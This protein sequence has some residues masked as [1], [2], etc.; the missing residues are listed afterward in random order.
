MKARRWDFARREY[1]EVE[2]ADTCSTY[3]DDF[4]S[5]VTC[6]GCGR[7]LP[8]GHTFTSFMYHD[9]VGFGYGVCEACHDREFLDRLCASRESGVGDE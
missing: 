4:E 3:K 5:E 8:F 9:R 2:I 1:D 6:P 7:A